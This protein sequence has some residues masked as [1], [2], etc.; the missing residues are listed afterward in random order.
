MKKARKG[1]KTCDETLS[2]VN[3]TVQAL[4]E[5][6]QIGSG[7]VDSLIGA[8]L[9]GLRRSSWDFLYGAE[10]IAVDNGPAEKSQC[11]EVPVS[12]PDPP[13]AVAVE[14][15][16]DD[17]LAVEERSYEEAGPLDWSP[18]SPPA[19]DVVERCPMAAPEEDDTEPEA[20]C[21]NSGREGVEEKAEDGSDTAGWGFT[22]CLECGRVD[23]FM[24]GSKT[25]EWGT[26]L[27]AGGS[28]H[29]G[30][31]LICCGTCRRTG[32]NHYMG[33]EAIDRANQQSFQHLK[34]KPERWGGVEVQGAARA[35][36]GKVL[37][38]LT[39]NGGLAYVEVDG[40]VKG[41]TPE[42]RVVSVDMEKFRKGEGG[43]L[44]LR[45]VIGGLT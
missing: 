4:Y 5:N 42:D 15:A 35:I 8:G 16:P 41:L 6:G 32:A 12:E 44:L 40:I 22:W 21:T 26:N 29:Q 13:D 34:I 19:D 18:P 30:I 20:A 9:T 27:D 25:L 24:Y 39:Y 36:V 43:D 33:E 1:V 28:A 45:G 37:P 23:I 17:D 31:V 38:F 11:S 7:A 14:V 2:S 10:A 3:T